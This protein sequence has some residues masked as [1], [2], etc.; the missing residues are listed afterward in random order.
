MIPRSSQE[1]QLSPKQ[2][3]IIETRFQRLFEWQNKTVGFL[4]ISF[5]LFLSRFHLLD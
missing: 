4:L 2:H 5:C 3:E 1:M